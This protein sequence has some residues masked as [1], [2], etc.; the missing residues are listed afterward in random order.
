MY[1]RQSLD[2]SNN[3][4][5]FSNSSW[6]LTDGEFNGNLFQRVSDLVTQTDG[7]GEGLI[8]NFYA[9]NFEPQNLE[10]N[11]P[12]VVT[13]GYEVGDIVFLTVPANSPGL[14]NATAFTIATVITE[15]M[16]AFEGDKIQYA[17]VFHNELGLTLLVLP[18]PDNL[19]DYWEVVQV[20][21]SHKVSWR[22]NI[23][24][25]NAGNRVRITNHIT[26]AF[27]RAAQDSNSHPTLELPAGV[28]CVTVESKQTNIRS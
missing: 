25:G 15:D 1:K 16:I 13:S 10:I 22:I 9:F 8:L 12:T 28:S 3:S 4:P 11:A 6:E 20:F 27:R 2:T 23:Q 21:A 5:L 17:P 19:Y 7:D 14:E 18:P 26:E 24:G